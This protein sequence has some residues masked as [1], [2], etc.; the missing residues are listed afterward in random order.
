MLIGDFVLEHLVDEAC[1]LVGGSH[2]GLRRA[3]AAL[4]A[5]IERAEGR[6]GAGDGSRR[7]AEG[8][9]GLVARLER[10][11]AQHLTT[12]SIILW[13]Q[14][15]PQA[16]LLHQDAHPLPALSAPG[17]GLDLSPRFTPSDG[18]PNNY[19]LYFP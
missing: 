14:A 8:L 18:N 17:T 6:I 10:A 11:T 1:E 16:E 19:D 4:E 7:R 3:D 13:C 15:Q 9:P 12:R 5:A 2:Q